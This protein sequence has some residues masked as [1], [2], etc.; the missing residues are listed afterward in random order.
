VLKLIKVASHLINLS[1]WGSELPIHFACYHGYY[2]TTKLLLEHDSNL[3]SSGT[4]VLLY[5]VRSNNEKIINLIIKALADRGIRL[6]ELTRLYLPKEKLL[7]IASDRIR[8]TDARFIV[9]ELSV[10][11]IHIL[12][13]LNGPNPPD[14]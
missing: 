5:A 8:D 6:Y 14:G 4:H 1:T 9:D 11:S 10:L 13:V 2:R 3:R 7:Q 12:E